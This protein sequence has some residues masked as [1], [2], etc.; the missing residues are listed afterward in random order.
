MYKHFRNGYYISDKG[1]VKRVR[2]GKVSKPKLCKT[3]GGYICFRDFIADERV[4]VHRA[5]AKCF[6]GNAPNGKW[7]VDHINRIRTDNRVDNLRWVS[8]TEN[9]KNRFN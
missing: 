7:Q 2:K 3:S 6:I 5:V 1:K 8:R 4:F 9:L